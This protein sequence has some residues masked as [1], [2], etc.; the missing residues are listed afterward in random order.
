MIIKRPTFV[1]NDTFTGRDILHKSNRDNTKLPSWLS[2]LIYKTTDNDNY[3]SGGSREHYFHFLLGYLLPIIHAQ[4]RN[5]FTSFNI[6]DCGP[7]MTPIIHETLNRLHYNF[8]IV[9]SNRIVKPYYLEPWE[10]KWP[11]TKDAANTIQTITNTWKNFECPCAPCN[12]SENILL[13]RSTPHEYYTNGESEISGYGISRR[14]ISNWPE[15]SRHLDDHDI[16]HLIYEP[17][18]HSLGCQIKTFSL[19]RKIVGMRGAEWANI[20]WCNLKVHAKI[21]DPY[22]PAIELTKLLQN[23]KVTYN[24][25]ST[26]SASTRIDPL[27][28]S[29]F[30]NSQAEH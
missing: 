17:G 4:T 6:L 26:D 2:C 19:A 27:S 5:K 3:I 1:R 15:I 22:P 18:L 25:S 21:F 20:I 28:V 30:L 12:T 24:F 7:L 11:S 23:R 9:N 29:T 8:K 16:N 13:K 10:Y 14:H